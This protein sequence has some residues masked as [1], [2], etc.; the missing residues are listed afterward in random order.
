MQ[1][2]GQVVVLRDVTWPAMLSEG[3][4]GLVISVT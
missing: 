1:Y 2:G 4:M 3:A